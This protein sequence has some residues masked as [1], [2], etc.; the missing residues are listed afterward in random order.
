MS[1][2]YRDYLCLPEKRKELIEI[3]RG[4][5][6]REEEILREKYTINFEARKNK[7]NENNNLENTNTKEKQ[8]T[9]Y[10]EPIFKRIVN[11]ILSFLHFKIKN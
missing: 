8:I 5:L 4:I 3:D 6:Q 1:L 10:K 2:I 11:K 9:E 7:I